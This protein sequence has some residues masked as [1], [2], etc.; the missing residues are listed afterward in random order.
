MN[1][2]DRLSDL[3]DILAEIEGQSSE[4]MAADLR[5]AGIDTDAFLKRANKVMQEQYRKHLHEL[6]EKEQ[7]IAHVVPSFFA[8]VSKMNREELMMSFATLQN[9][10]L[11][12]TYKQ[13]ALARCRNKDTAELSD[14]D[15]RSWLQDIAEISGNTDGNK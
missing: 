12:E 1:N 14:D 5:K 6:A 3:E 4:E 13:A 10:S 15:L 2:R 11:G 9:G 7:Q 8:D